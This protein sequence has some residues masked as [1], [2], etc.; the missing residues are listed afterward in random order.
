MIRLIISMCLLIILFYCF[1]K[2]LSANKRRDKLI[3]LS[4]NKI[5]DNENENKFTEN[6]K[7]IQVFDI[8][9]VEYKVDKFDYSQ[10]NNILKITIVPN[11][12]NFH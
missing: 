3:K 6:I 9:N 5:Q 8:H 1:G 7:I 2:F 10:P 11:S 12:K 4:L